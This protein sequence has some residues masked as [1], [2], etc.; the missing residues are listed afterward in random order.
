M[1]EEIIS[2][3][4]GI[5]ITN[6]YWGAIH[7]W[8]SGT[9]PTPVV[10]YSFSISPTSLTITYSEQTITVTAT[11]DSPSWQVLSC[12]SWMN[13]ESTTQ[14]G[15]SWVME[16]SVEENEGTV[17]SSDIEFEYQ[18]D[19]EGT[20]QTLQMPVSQNRFYGI[21]YEST[22]NNIVALN[23][24]TGFGANY[25]SNTYTSNGGRIEFDDDITA[26]TAF[27]FSGQTNLYKITIPSSVIR[28]NTTI[29]SGCTSLAEFTIPDS[30]TYLGAS[31]FRGCSSLKSFT[32]G[33]G[34]TSIP[35]YSFTD[36]VTLTSVTLSSTL[37]SIGTAAFRDCTTLPEITL[38]I[39][40]TTIGGTVFQRCQGLNDIYYEGTQSQYSS[41]SKGSNW[42]Q[43][44]PATVVHCSDG[45][46][47]I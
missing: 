23:V 45:N 13:L 9:P 8:P 46:A 16:F 5:P 22:N 44:V 31:N 6:V 38:P 35:N 17:R 15:E 1:S 7:I 34:L 20:T 4:S 24:T 11:T 21:K 12:P 10:Y 28:I 32:F 36:C 14:V 27:A 29:F 40:L 3:T 19:S 18:S 37:R 42:H 2:V 43:N 41:I 26:I 30:V 33:T 39:S 47:P 25:V